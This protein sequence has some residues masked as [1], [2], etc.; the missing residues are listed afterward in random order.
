MKNWSG[1]T[2]ISPVWR[3]R[4]ALPKT[5]TKADFHPSDVK[6]LWFLHGV[7]A[8]FLRDYLSTEQLADLYHESL[9]LSVGAY[10]I[11]VVCRCVDLDEDL[12]NI[13]ADTGVAFE[14]WI[15]SEVDAQGQFWGKEVEYSCP[16]AWAGEQ[17]T[18]QSIATA[19]S[20]R[21]VGRE[22]NEAL[23]FMQIEL[24]A[25]LSVLKGRSLGPFSVLAD[26]A[27]AVEA[28][29]NELVN[30]E[31]GAEDDDATEA[32]VATA[33][34][35][36][37][38]PDILLTLNAGLS[39]LSSQALSG[40]API[41]RTECHFWPHSFLGTGVANLALRNVTAFLTSLTHRCQ[42]DRRL[43]QLAFKP[44][45]ITSYSIQKPD[46]GFPDFACIQR[47]EVAN[48]NNLDAITDAEMENKAGDIGEPRT[49]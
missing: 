31:S 47:S 32:G 34:R 26:D 18:G 46:P 30:G 3:L 44:F 45:D 7:S 22:Q 13:C 27:L 17:K 35:G 23:R 20:I 16:E 36:V 9:W 25:L 33:T 42:Y 24:Y 37:A 14:R 41:L 8:D 40:T 5:I 15:V 48:T 39:R 28:L 21:K 2:R 1:T 4:P 11:I 29:A 6:V 12:R 49:P 43:Y 38:R 10:S 19:A